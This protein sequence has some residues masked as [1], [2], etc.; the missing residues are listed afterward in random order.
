ME[1]IHI[2]SF[3]DSG[4]EALAAQ[5]LSNSRAVHGF[6]AAAKTKKNGKKLGPI[7]LFKKLL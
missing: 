2:A 4:P 6:R 3:S 1:M 5:L 7:A